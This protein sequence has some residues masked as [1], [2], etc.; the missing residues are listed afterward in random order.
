MNDE[1][2]FGKYLREYR[3]A[4]G[5]S[6][7]GLHRITGVSQPYLSQLESGTKSPSRKT[8]HKIAAG[9][10]DDLDTE[11]TFSA[12]YK[13]LLK[14][15]GYNTDWEFI[16]D[17]DKEMRNEIETGKNQLNLIEHL[18]DLKTF[19]NS[20]LSIDDNE[21]DISPTYNGHNLTEDQRKKIM[22]MVE[23]MYPEL[24]ERWK[25]TRIKRKK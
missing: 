1:N 5:L 7:S 18:T 25:P 24:K 14:R 17:I 16:D 11:T 2:V 3:E 9:L 23:L 4:N 13:E 19:L 15:A 8:I 12:M 22:D 10:T 20:D 21:P 6:I